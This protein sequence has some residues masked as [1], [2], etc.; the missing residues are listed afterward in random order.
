MLPHLPIRLPSIEGGGPVGE[1]A[2][3]KE[4]VLYI[5]NFGFIDRS[6][7]EMAKQARS[8]AT[9]DRIMATA[10]SEFRAHGF[11]GAAISGICK[12][13][14]VSPGHLY[15]YFDSKEAIVEAIVEH[16]RAKISAEIAQLLATEEPLTAMVDAML[17]DRTGDDGM[18]TIMTI[19]IY[20]E[21][22]R[23][24]RV[25]RIVKNFERHLLSEIV[26]MLTSLERAGRVTP[27]LD[28]TA[29]ASVL[30]ALVDGVLTRSIADPDAGT[31]GL[32]PALNTVI[33]ALLPCP[34]S[35]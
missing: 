5:C 11:R 8:V 28:L 17:A 33:A 21:A 14:G 7:L 4:R 16:E 24:L 19:E 30:M 32:K 18:D 29:I 20:A 35:K 12:S 3:G 6:E 1:L 34:A 13:A 23:N 27:G 9:L 2:I 15:H 31:D 22:T 10:V 25:A 26:A